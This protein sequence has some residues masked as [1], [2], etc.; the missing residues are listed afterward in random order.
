MTEPYIVNVSSIQD[1]YQC[2]YRWLCKW[3]LNRVPKDDALALDVGKLIHLFFE[4]HFQNGV[5][6][7]EACAAQCQALIEAVGKEKAEPV[8]SKILDFMEA[9]PQ[10]RDAYPFEVAVLEVEQPFQVSFPEMPGVIFRGRP[11]RVGIMSG[12]IWHVQNRGLAASENFGT[13]VRKA[14]RHY[15]EHLYAEYLSQKYADLGPYGGTLF[16]LIRKLKYRT[17]A[18]KKNEKVKTAVEMFWQHP[19]SVN[20]TA[21][22][23]KAVMHDMF[24][25]VREMQRVEQLWRTE[26]RLPAPNEKYGFGHAEDPFLKVLLG[27]ADLFDDRYFKPREETYE[28][29]HDAGAGSVGD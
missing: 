10:W 29:V 27:E 3:V 16:N 4:D 15:H 12:C 23:H 2:R 7:A 19:M 22:F 24:E 5:P 17:Y 28:E 1:F 9:L 18:G 8:V 6:L 21:P 13:Y 11:D 20:I 26:R 25:H 14:K